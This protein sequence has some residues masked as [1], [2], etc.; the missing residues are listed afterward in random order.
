M[1]LAIKATIIHGV[2][3]IKSVYWSRLFTIYC[4]AMEFRKHLRNKDGRK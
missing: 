4:I 1:L 3:Q 2:Q